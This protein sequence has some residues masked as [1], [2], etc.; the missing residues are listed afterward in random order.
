MDLS[1]FVRHRYL[2]VVAA[3][4]QLVLYAPSTAVDP[5]LVLPSRPHLIRWS[6]TKNERNGRVFSAET[7]LACTLG[8]SCG[9]K[10]A[11]RLSNGGDGSALP[12]IYKRICTISLVF[13]SPFR[14]VKGKTCLFQG[15]LSYA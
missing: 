4:G 6:S 5:A 9:P 15:Y 7:R 10:N 2:L 3:V 1:H 12:N 11:A 8:C 13:Q 14:A